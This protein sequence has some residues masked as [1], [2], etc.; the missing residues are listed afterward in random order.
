[1]HYVTFGFRTLH[2]HAA[3]FYDYL[4]LRKRFFVDTLGWAIPHD[5]W[6][7]MDQYDN[8]KARYA[9]VIGDEGQVLAGARALPTSARWGDVTYMLRDAQAGRIGGIPADL[10]GERV[11]PDTMYECTRLVIS[12]ELTGMQSRVACLGLICRGLVDMAMDD[13]A[14]E[15]MSLSNLWL[16]R[17]LKA[18]GY[19]AELMCAPY[20][21]CDDGHKYAVMK[22][23]AMYVAPTRAPANLTARSA[24]PSRQMQPTLLHAA[25]K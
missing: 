12:P 14:T 10:L 7:E 15:L 25:A 21:N 17:A 19:D 24:G 4:A 13:G 23:S 2:D 1:M 5:D 8:P 6:V 20:V 22:M 3:S 9:L 16:L 18:L 11:L